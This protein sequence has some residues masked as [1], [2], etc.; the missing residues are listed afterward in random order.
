MFMLETKVLV[1]DD[2]L[3]MR[4]IVSKVC[5]ELGF[6]NITEAADGDLAWQAVSTNGA[7]FGLVISDWNMPNLNG[8]EFLKKLRADPI[9]KITPFVM[10]TAR[11]EI[12]QV[13]EALKAGIDNYIV[14]PFTAE[15]LKIKLE[16]TYKKTSARSAAS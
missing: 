12:G 3:S 7:N 10:L 1:V 11:S 16:E 15:K 2:M 5:R 13:A 6:K 9:L 8:L 4:K 14:K